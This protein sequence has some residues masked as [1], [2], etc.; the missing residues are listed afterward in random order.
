MNG[1]PLTTEVMVYL[2]PAW[3]FKAHG[4]YKSMKLKKAEI[5]SYGTTYVVETHYARCGEGLPPKRSFL[6][7]ANPPFM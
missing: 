1:S 6:R 2:V 7:T 3:L 5:E 4:D